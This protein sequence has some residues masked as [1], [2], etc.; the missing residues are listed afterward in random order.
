LA[1]RS[2]KGVDAARL[3]VDAIRLL[4]YISLYLLLLA[5]DHSCEL[6]LRPPEFL[7]EFLLDLHHNTEQRRCPGDSGNRQADRHHRR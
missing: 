3:P 1:A 4:L 7:P 2:R 6:A 5:K